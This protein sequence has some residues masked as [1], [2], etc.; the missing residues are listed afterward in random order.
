M[1][2]FRRLRPVFA[3]FPAPEETNGG[4]QL[5][6]GIR[7]DI[8]LKQLPK[9]AT[10]ELEGV[11]FESQGIEK[12]FGDAGL[13]SSAPAT[14]RD[15]REH[16]FVTL[17]GQ[18][19]RR[20]LRAFVSE[21][22]F[23]LQRFVST[24]WQ[25]DGILNSLSANVAPGF[26][27]SVSALR[28][29]IYAVTNDRLI[30]RIEDVERLRPEEIPFNSGTLTSAEDAA[31]FTENP[32]FVLVAATPIEVRFRVRAFLNAEWDSLR[33]QLEFLDAG[34]NVIKTRTFRTTSEDIDGIESV[35]LPP[36]DTFYGI[37]IASINF[38][39]GPKKPVESRVLNLNVAGGGA[40]GTRPESIGDLV[41]TEFTFVFAVTRNSGEES[42]VDYFIRWREV[43]GTGTWNVIFIG[44]TGEG[45]QEN[46]IINIPDITENAE[47]QVLLDDS[48]FDVLFARV[49]YREFAPL[50]IEPGSVEI[51]PLDIRFKTS[52]FIGPPRLEFLEEA[53]RAFW[54]D[55]F[56]D[57]V[58]AL[59]DDGDSQVLSIS[60][61][62]SYSDWT[63]P[64]SDQ[65][66][67]LDTKVEPIDALQCTAAVG[68]EFV[69]LIR[70]RSIMRVF[71]SG[72]A[73]PPVIVQTW[74]EGLG[75]NS[76][77]SAQATPFGAIFLG[78]DRMVYV[79]TT[80]GETAI[81][82]PILP[83]LRNLNFNDRAVDST[84]DS[85][86]REYLLSIPGH[87][88]YIANFENEGQPI[89]R[90]RNV[91]VERITTTRIP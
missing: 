52:E 84:Y 36:P 88:V 24:Q 81:G 17:N 39:G 8:A 4:D 30:A 49:E 28:V 61:S 2:K 64:G 13:G 56:A 45:T 51:E 46:R 60:A 62:G 65:I 34:S 20:L 78:S 7:R 44:Q 1:N 38:S 86:N 19:T 75:T 16:G 76:P 40:E 71:L 50:E 3:D 12:D 14:I 21:G 35:F 22:N 55:S 69:A 85:I 89:W 87:G 10:Y 23:T 41:N 37:R 70:S 67:I 31:I 57:R 33:F 54:V 43:A 66:T 26:V 11:R 59:W 48:N 72:R 74:I 27:R 53:P 5:S 63:G 90:F 82:A 42:F 25:A 77:F 32:G 15:I 18:E 29:V 6:Y 73:S 58:L 68:G 9:G 80:G 91:S 47:F 83:I 79:L